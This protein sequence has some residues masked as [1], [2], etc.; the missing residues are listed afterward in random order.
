[1]MIP[2]GSEMLET[3]VNKG[4]LAAILNVTPA[5]V[6]AWLKRYPRFPVLGRGMQGREW[7]FDPAAVVAFVAAMREAERATEA[8]RAAGVA[9]L[10][11]ALTDPGDASAVGGF[12]LAEVKTARLADQV[13]AE[14]SF[15][16]EV[17][18]MAEALA[19]ALAMW[20]RRV[21][22]LLEAAGHDLNI[23]ADGLAVM[24]KSMADGRRQFTAEAAAALGAPVG[25]PAP[26]GL[27]LGPSA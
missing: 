26:G 13:R 5:T 12:S 15:L 3:S 18:A 16:V 1:M 8:E 10:G 9:Q 22:E 25:G 23:P 24:A 19:D 2:V 27:P 4:E 20:D 21:A 7:R 11:L 6:T 14:R 17:S